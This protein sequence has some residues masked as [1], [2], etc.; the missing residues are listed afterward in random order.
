MYARLTLGTTATAN[1]PAGRQ[2][3]TREPPTKP[4]VAV[5]HN[6]VTRPERPIPS[7]HRGRP[8]RVHAAG[9][10]ALVHWRVVDGHQHP[11]AS[12]RSCP[13]CVAIPHSSAP[14]LPLQSGRHRRCCYSCCCR[15]GGLRDVLLGCAVQPPRC[16]SL[17]LLPP[18]PP[19][20]RSPGHVYCFLR[21]EV[22]QRGSH[23]EQR[24]GHK[25]R[26][27]CSKNTASFGFFWHPV[28]RV[29]RLEVVH[30]VL[31]AVKRSTWDTPR[32]PHIQKCIPVQSEG[33][34]RCRVTSL[35]PVVHP[36]RRWKRCVRMFALVGDYTRVDHRAP[37]VWSGSEQEHR[38]RVLP[39]A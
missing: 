13:V 29:V 26:E 10:C 7:P 31:V 11:L 6:H 5:P 16:P 18:M 39:V 34:V 20:A 22:H 8:P 3:A 37:L 2:R 15:C 33:E 19:P 35:V 23:C 38:V 12:P 17:E 28:M 30:L 36:L 21:P 9:S 14:P 32:P 4:S 24:H 27:L 1:R 25:A